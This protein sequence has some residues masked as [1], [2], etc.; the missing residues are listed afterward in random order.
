[1]ADRTDPKRADKEAASREEPAA[2]TPSADTGWNW[3]LPAMPHVP[4][5][6]PRPDESQAIFRI[7]RTAPAPTDAARW[8]DNSAWMA[9]LRLYRAG[10]FWEAHEVWEAVWAHARP[11]SPERMLAQGVIQLAN[12]GLK[13]R[14]GRPG[15][16]LRLAELARAHLDDVAGGASHRVM[17]LDPRALAEATAAYARALA[18]GAEAPVPLL[19]IAD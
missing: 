2:G 19:E 3:P 15:A 12:A 5:A 4:G 16:A 8:R 10:F 14:M 17:G 18:E 6:T 1:M 9:G 7:A 13:Q 11:N